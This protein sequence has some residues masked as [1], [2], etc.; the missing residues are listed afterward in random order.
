[1]LTRL[2][3]SSATFLACFTASPALAQTAYP[4]LMSLKPT[5]AQVG[6]TSEHTLSSR[7]DMNGAYEVLVSEDGVTGEIVLP[8]AKPDE[9]DKKPKSLTAL[10]V[11]FTVAAGT[12]PGVRDFRIATPRGVSTLGQLVIVNDPI[13]VE[14]SDNNT[15]DKAQPV[16]FPA[17]LCGVIEKAED[18]DYFKFTAEADTV[19][20]FHVRSM[21]LQN[22]IHDLQK[23]SDPIISVQSASGATLAQSDN[24]YAGDPFLSHRFEQAGEHLL[25]IR[26][27]RY[28]GNAHWTYSIEVTSEP[29]VTS[30]HPM[31]LAPGQETELAIVS[32]PALDSARSSVSLA[33]DLPHGPKKIRL[34][35]VD[36]KLS[37]PVGVVVSDLPAVV[38]SD[39]DNNTPEQAQVISVPAGI[40][41]RIESEAD[42]DCYTF[43]AKKG[44][45]FSIEIVARRQQSALDSFVRIL[46][47]SGKSI[48]QQDDMSLY[49]LNFA[50]SWIE[51]W[52]APADGKFTIEVRDL[53]LRG[54]PDYVYFLKVT[55]SQPYFELYLD[56]DKTLL[57]PGTSGVLFAR[58][59]R[60]NG[61][62]G[63]VTLNIEGLPEA[64]TAKCGVIPAGK[65][66]DGCIIL[67]AAP[68]TGMC[69]ANV[70][71]SGT[72]QHK[73]GDDEM[74]DLSSVAV[75]MQETYMPGG[76]RNH[77]QVD[78]H[79]V[80]VGAPGD[81]R[82]VKLDTNEISLKP[83]E[84]K[85]VG[86]VIERAEGFTKN[87]TLDSLFQHLGGVFGNTLPAGVTIDGSQS[88]TLLTGSMSEGHITFKAAAN[89][90]PGEK[91]QV[92]VMANIALN[93]VMKSTFSSEP[94]SVGIAEP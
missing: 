54:G 86:V 14:T 3:F 57:T 84:S 75:P 65:P 78:M 16:S 32:A 71:V 8:E 23:H 59:V 15:P 60:K 55:R 50:D 62:Q 70:V 42:I 79:T 64:V 94:L 43:E 30:V 93:F 53:H 63:K 36:D 48:K 49:R 85:K 90:K 26:D 31:G 1:M 40:S 22:R 25:E 5:A 80:S 41:G 66:V 7:Y 91:R 19:L 89:A 58:V 38:E 47:S 92:P 39:V 77:W 87:V 81:I 11:R 9:K 33:A 17:T 46:D 44:E 10:K 2:F 72:A 24:S 18:V 28:Q 83:G 27:V 74:L 29:F 73:T 82:A 52:S 21:R 13:A 37:N 69:A 67:A 56:T 12:S 20:N 45:K 34:P 6:G 4:M 61:F 35:M 88:K 68:G 76:G 51:N